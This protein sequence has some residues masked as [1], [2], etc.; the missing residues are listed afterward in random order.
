M[1]ATLPDGRVLITAGGDSNQ[2][3][4]DATTSV[5][6][7]HPTSDTWS[8]APPMPDPRQAATPVELADGSVL[9]VG[10]SVDG[11]ESSTVLASATRFVPSP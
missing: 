1:V 3:A 10:G 11:P 5:E 9:L 4:G 7:Y 8:P 6:F 2:S